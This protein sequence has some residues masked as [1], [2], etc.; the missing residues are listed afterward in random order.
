[1]NRRHGKPIFHGQGGSTFVVN[2]ICVVT[3]RAPLVIRSI[4]LPSRLAA[5]IIP[6][7]FFFFSSP[8]H[9]EI[10]TVYREK[11]C[12]HGRITLSELTISHFEIKRICFSNSITDLFKNKTRREMKE[13]KSN[14]RDRQLITSYNNRLRQIIP[15]TMIHFIL[16]S[17]DQEYF[18]EPASIAI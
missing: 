13:W 5:E 3:L 11:K 16:L 1:M 12:L 18:R 8:K 17:T 15:S 14:R 9:D 2:D 10:F 4:E 6:F 7:F